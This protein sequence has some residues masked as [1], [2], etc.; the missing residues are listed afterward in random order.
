MEVTL[1]CIGDVVGRPGRAVVS[2]AVPKLVRER[3]VDCVIANVENAAA[4]SGLTQQLYAKF[5]R[6]G[7]NVMTMGDHIY[8]KADI[9]PVLEQSEQIVRPVNYPAEAAGRLFAIHTTAS[10]VKIAVMSVMGRLFMQ[11]PADCPF[12]AM[13]RVLETLPSDVKVIVVDMHGE[14][15]SEKVA[16]GWH[17]EGRV[18]VLFGTH[19]HVQTADERVLE[20]GTAYITDLGMSGPYDGVLGRR[21]DRVLK[22]LTTGMPAPFD[23]AVGDPRMCGILVRVEAETGRATHIERVCVLGTA[24]SAENDEGE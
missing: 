8:R 2:Q 7:V 6:Y 5:L 17:L 23:V 14:A 13:D 21:K 11:P 9:L 20:G 4:G 19:T 3:Q 18:S 1:L 10:G 22:A 24:E 16:M 12:H 15:T